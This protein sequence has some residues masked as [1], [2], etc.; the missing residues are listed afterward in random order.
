MLAGFVIA[1]IVA[2]AIALIT[3]QT[4]F[5]LGLFPSGA[6]IDSMDNAASLGLGIAILAVPMTFAA[7]PP[8]LV[9]R[10]HRSL[11]LP[12]ML[13]IGGAIG[14]V[15]LALIVA[16]ILAVQIAHGQPVTEAGKLWEGMSG[17]SVRV[18]MGLVCGIGTAAIFWVV[19]LAGVE[20]ESEKA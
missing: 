12:T 16:G 9:L 19:A 18:A 4:F 20:R 13:L 15:P 7:V 3:Y 17:L 6:S 1:P 8:V 2:T 5:N 14:N 10:E 11:S